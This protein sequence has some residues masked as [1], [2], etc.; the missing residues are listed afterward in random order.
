MCIQ[1]VQ[2]RRGDGLFEQRAQITQPPRAMMQGFLRSTFQG[3]DRMLL[4]QRQQAVQ[5]RTPMGPRCCTIASAQL[6]VCAPISR[7][8]SSK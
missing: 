6:P 1:K 4:G 3:F 5:N 2:L 8:R 7:A